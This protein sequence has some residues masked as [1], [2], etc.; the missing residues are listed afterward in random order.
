MLTTLSPLGGK[1]KPLKAPK[2]QNKELD[3]DDQAF[4]EKKRA[5]MMRKVTKTRLRLTLVQRRRLA[6]SWQPRSAAVESTFPL[7]G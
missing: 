4:L 7:R 1:A 3:E 2:K 6:R 5:G